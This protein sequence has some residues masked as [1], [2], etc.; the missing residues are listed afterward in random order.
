MRKPLRFAVRRL[1][2]ERKFRGVNT[3][4]VMSALATGRYIIVLGARDE[5]LSMEPQSEKP[6]TDTARS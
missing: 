3:C 2:R 6:E 4:G 5:V 1:M